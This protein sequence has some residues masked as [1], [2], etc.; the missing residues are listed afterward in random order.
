MPN[1]LLFDRF[2]GKLSQFAVGFKVDPVCRADSCHTNTR[3]AVPQG[4]TM[5]A[6]EALMPPIGQRCRKDSHG[7]P[8][9]ANLHGNR[10]VC[11]GRL[12]LKLELGVLALLEHDILRVKL[13]DLASFTGP[14]SLI[15]G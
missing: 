15:I 11:L 7:L 13:L 10:A 1:R 14:V 8:P 6:E 3:L 9:D 2:Y 12:V 5:R 4:T